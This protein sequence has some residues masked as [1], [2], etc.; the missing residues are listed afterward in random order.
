MSHSNH[1]WHC[2][3]FF[4]RSPVTETVFEFWVSKI[5]TDKNLSIICALTENVTLR[6][7]YPTI[8]Y[9]KVYKSFARKIK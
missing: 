6:I 7:M 4:V 8:M 1:R 5:E 3:E 2:L 9:E